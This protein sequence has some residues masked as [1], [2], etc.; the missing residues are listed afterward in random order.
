MKPNATMATMTKVAE[1]ATG[2]AATGVAARSPALM[3][4][5]LFRVYALTIGASSLPR[6]LRSAQ[7]P[8][9]D[10]DVS[11]VVY[12]KKGPRPPN[13]SDVSLILPKANRPKNC[14]DVFPER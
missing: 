13:L 4:P 1:V 5:Y 6:I 10:P 12:I 9:Q 2:V 14:L 8:T 7:K 3:A 11:F